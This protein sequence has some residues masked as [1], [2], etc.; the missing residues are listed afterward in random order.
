VTP[1]GPEADHPTPILEL[2]DPGGAAT[3]TTSE[4]PSGNAAIVAAANDDSARALGII[5]IALGAVALLFATA[6]LMRRRRS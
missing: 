5:G 1:N 6:A 3:P 2:T 4:P